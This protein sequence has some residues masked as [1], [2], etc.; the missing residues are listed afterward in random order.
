MLRGEGWG[1]VSLQGE[2]I[3]LDV[4]EVINQ[5]KERLVARGLTLAQNVPIPQTDRSC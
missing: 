3:V 4:D 5:V 1:A 2:Q